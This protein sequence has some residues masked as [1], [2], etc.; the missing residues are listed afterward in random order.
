MGY[1]MG[2]VV[3]VWSLQSFC[4]G[5]FL[6]GETAIVFQ[7][8]HKNASSVLL[9]VTRKINGEYMLDQSYE[10]YTQQTELITPSTISSKENMK[11]FK[12]L[13]Q[14][15]RTHEHEKEMAGDRK[16][17]LG[18]SYSRECFIGEDNL[19]HLDRESLLY[20]ESFI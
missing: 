2:D 17:F 6:K 20:P 11:W 1:T 7:D 3:K 16:D 5:G 15:L 9:T 18:Y 13:N 4:N 19:I 10:V 14:K 12:E 8:Q